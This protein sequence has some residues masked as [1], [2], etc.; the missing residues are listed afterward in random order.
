MKNI[1]LVLAVFFAGCSK[2][3]GDVPEHIPNASLVLIKPAEGQV[4]AAGDSIAVV[5]TAISDQ[6][7]HGYEIYLRAAGDTAK[8]YSVNVHD[9]NDSLFID[10]KFKYVHS[11][12]GAAELHV[13]LALDHEGHELHVRKYISVQ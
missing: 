6:T 3:A 1:L 7:I 5:G 4:F 2:H 10:R 13:V 11:Y 8:L 9:H 12:R